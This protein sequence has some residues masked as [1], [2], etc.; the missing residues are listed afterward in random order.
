MKAFYFFDEDD[1][2]N[3][4]ADFQ[5]LPL[6]VSYLDA[7]C[8]DKITPASEVQT[9]KTWPSQRSL[10]EPKPLILDQPKFCNPSPID[11]QTDKRLPDVKTA[12]LKS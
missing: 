1:L 9:P 11:E 3:L 6:D 12:Q 5:L 4:P 8:A 2:D 10:Q 7:I